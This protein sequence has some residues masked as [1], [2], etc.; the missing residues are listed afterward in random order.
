M[1]IYEHKNYKL[2]VLVPVF[3]LLVGL[4]FI[5]KIQLDSSLKGGI[6]ITLNT[7]SPVANATQIAA[8][9]NQK[10]P[11]SSAKVSKINANNISISLDANTSL[12]DTE[13]SLLQIYAEYKN[14]SGA[15]LAI[16]SAQILLQ[17]KS[18]ANA[19]QLRSSIASQ[20]AL[21][22]KYL[23]E[24]NSS[25]KTELGYASKIL[26]SA[27]FN[28][29]TASEM[30]SSAQGLYLN[31]SNAYKKNTLN[32]LNEIAPYS[33]Y[34]YN[35][36]TP[37][38]G[39]Y[40][41]KKIQQILIIS[42]IL[43]AIA[44]FVIFRNPVP[45][46]AVIFG[47]GNDIIVALGAMGAFGIPLGVASIGAL[48]ML[49]GYSMDTDLLAS[50]RI[51]KRS[52]NTATERAFSTMKT[53]LTMT[54]AAVIAFAVLFSVSYITGI[55]TFFEISAVMLFGLIGDIFTT[56]LGNT[57]LILWYKHRCK[58]THKKF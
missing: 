29:S 32:T 44:V 7:N 26:P 20:T 14:Y 47:A 48:L 40:F 30:M 36:V 15:I 58:E 33:S 19:S 17:N 49:I 6:S 22:A 24:M 35:N 12:A 28:S 43:V 56:W 37:S 34:S 52:E 23:S 41:L 10:I 46:L 50:V 27:S 45:S 51:L 8:L 31:A 25:L 16:S 55:S 13:I 18:I 53:G 5:P 57:T 3:L 4:Y 11:G 38:L 42:F 1:N 9:I 54:G 2:F 21:Q 39:Q